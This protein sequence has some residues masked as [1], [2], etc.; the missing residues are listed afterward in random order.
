MN[1]MAA[2]QLCSARA[3]RNA[4]T[5]FPPYTEVHSLDFDDHPFEIQEW[6]EACAICGAEDS[7]LDEIITDDSGRTHVCVFRYRLLR[8]NESGSA[9]NMNIVRTGR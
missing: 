4:S 6:D 2:L 9:A 5:Q 1:R 7:F 8:V 3:A